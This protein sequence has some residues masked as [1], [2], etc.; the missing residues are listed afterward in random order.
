DSVGYFVEEADLKRMFSE[1]DTSGDGLISFDEY[2]LAMGFTLTLAHKGESLRRIFYEIDEQN[3]G[4]IYYTKI[5]EVLEELKRHFF[6]ADIKRIRENALLMKDSEG[7]IDYEEFL[8]KLM[9]MKIIIIEDFKQTGGRYSI[10]KRKTESNITTVVT[11]TTTTRRTFNEEE[12]EETQTKALNG[13]AQDAVEETI[14][15]QKANVVEAKISEPCVTKTTTISMTSEQNNNKNGGKVQYAMHY[16]PEDE[17]RTLAILGDIPELG[18]WDASKAVLAEEYKNSG[19]WTVNL[20][21]KVPA[22]KNFEWKW[23]V[24][25]KNR[26][27]VLRWEIESGGKNRVGKLGTEGAELWFPWKDWSNTV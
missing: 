6:R 10:E 7:Y 2:M 18:A 8:K 22:G 21:E 4:K 3:T 11:E 1:T 27:R 16:W 25:D 15:V 24:V 23:V 12:I 5:E 13:N 14:T 9:S 20:S 19:W 17:N 26:P